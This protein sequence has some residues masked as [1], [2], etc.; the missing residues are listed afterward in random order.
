MVEHKCPVC[1]SDKVFKR[2]YVRKVKFECVE[3]GFN[4]EYDKSKLADVVFVTEYGKGKE[5]RD[6]VQWCRY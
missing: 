6:Y 4:A 3:C 5:I 2:D 1:E